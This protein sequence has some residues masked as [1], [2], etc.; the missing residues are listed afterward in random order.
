MPSDWDR[1]VNMAPCFSP[2]HN[3]LNDSPLHL[4]WP[5]NGRPSCHPL[6]TVPLQH[7]S[8]QSCAR[9]LPFSLNNC[10][11]EVFKKIHRAS[12]QN[13]KHQFPRHETNEPQKTSEQGQQLLI[14]QPTT[15]C[16]IPTTPSTKVNP[17]LFVTPRFMSSLWHG[18]MAVPVHE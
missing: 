14:R 18:C 3:F 1:C 13:K 5:Q 2:Q 8:S 10:F 16:S 11:K 17:I 9:Q 4:Q 15:L 6:Q 7:P 12:L